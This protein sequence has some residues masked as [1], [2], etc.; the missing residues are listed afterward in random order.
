MK[1]RAIALTLG[2]LILCSIGCVP[3]RRA[4]DLAKANRTL[5][6]QVVE[7]Q[8]RIRELNQRI[9]LMQGE[10]AM[11]LEDYTVLVQQR[12]ALQEQLDQAQQNLA[13]LRDQNRKLR[14]DLARRPMTALPPELDTKLKEF[15]SRY[16]NIADYDSAEGAVRF[17]S[18]LTFPLGSTDLS[19]E[20]RQSLKGLAEI[21]NSPEASGYEARIIGHTD[22]VPIRKPAT[23]AKHPT[24][25]HL[26][27]HRAI[28]VMDELT[29]DGVPPYRVFVGGYGMYRPEVA[30]EPRRGAE[31]N[32]RVEIYLV[33][34]AP[35]DTDMFAPGSGNNAGDSGNQASNASGT[36]GSATSDSTT[37]TRT[38]PLMNK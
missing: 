37:T 20:A 5:K 12:D 15:A 18:D 11:R 8:E 19:A 2:G 25:W 28:A 3:Q 26:S 16:S 7:L 6:E 29:N 9:E 31:A 32:R 14:S 10:S 27:V 1:T 17:K 36:S 21:I 35:V 22:N 4:D 13:E 33:P 38:T 23:R 34:M 24:N 30:N